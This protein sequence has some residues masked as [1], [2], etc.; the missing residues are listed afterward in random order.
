M[1]Q[2]L[3]CTMNEEH[4]YKVGDDAKARVRQPRLGVLCMC[5]I[6]VLGLHCTVTPA[7]GDVLDQPAN[8][9]QPDSSP[10]LQEV[11]A[12]NIARGKK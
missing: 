6:A 5:L 9:T 11:N 4:L 7:H 3:G 12:A 1:S 2:P 8:S 10:R